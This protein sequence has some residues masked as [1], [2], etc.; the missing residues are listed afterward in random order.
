VVTMAGVERPWHRIPRTQGLFKVEE[1][2]F[3]R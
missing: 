2:G 3:L 1:G